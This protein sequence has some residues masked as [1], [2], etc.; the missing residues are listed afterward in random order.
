MSFPSSSSSLSSSKNT[1]KF[2]LLISRWEMRRGSFQCWPSGTGYTLYLLNSSSPWYHWNLC[3]RPD[4][5]NV[6]TNQWSNITDYCI[7]QCSDTRLAAV[8]QAL[9]FLIQVHTC[10]YEDGSFLL[11]VIIHGTIAIQF[12]AMCLTLSFHGSLS[13]FNI[14]APSSSFLTLLLKGCLLYTSPSPRD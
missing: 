3:I 8:R 11:D 7:E 6:G 5:P 13:P 4:F 9:K 2:S 1:S 14:V 10:L 12:C